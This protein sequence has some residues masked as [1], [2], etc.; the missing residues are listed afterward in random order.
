MP[1]WPANLS[2]LCN[3]ITHESIKGLPAVIRDDVQEAFYID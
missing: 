1:I 3:K 2:E